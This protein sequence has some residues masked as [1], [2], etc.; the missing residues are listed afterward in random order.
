[1]LREDRSD[2]EGFDFSFDKLKKLFVENAV[3]GTFEVKTWSTDLYMY[4][5][6]EGP[7]V[8]SV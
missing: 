7:G 4:L 6:G 1:M 2:L 5:R 8:T 3:S